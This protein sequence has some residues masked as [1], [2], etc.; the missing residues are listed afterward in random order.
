MDTE[1]HSLKRVWKVASRWSEDGN[2]GSS[3]L[4]LFRDHKV[5]FVGRVPE[6]FSQIQLGDLLVVS[7]GREVVAMGTALSKPAP[8]TSLPI[9]FSEADRQR[10]HYENWVLSCAIAWV[11]LREEDF[12]HY[13]PGA[14]HE[15]HENAEHYR[16]LY[17]K[18]AA[19]SRDEGEFEIQ[20]RSCTLAYNE[21]ESANVLWRN[22]TRYVIPIFQ[23]AYS[24][25][26]AEVSRLVNDLLDAFSGRLG[27]PEREPMFIGTMQI[28]NR[29]KCDK[30]PFEWQHHVIDGQQRLTTLLLL[31]DPTIATASMSPLISSFS[32]WTPQKSPA[33]PGRASCRCR[34]SP[35]TKVP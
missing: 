6:K 1:S 33:Q 25:G 17:R 2:E 4:D 28:E 8:I 9:L 18:Y 21:R 32:S 10:F 31:M 11:D 19:E 12:V 13:R 30:D 20:A 29:V 5:V 34:P 27:G 23:R 3:V 7:D 35:A 24:W 22:S 16:D 14:F 26:Q 15:V